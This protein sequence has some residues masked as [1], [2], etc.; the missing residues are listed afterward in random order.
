MITSI[1]S[2]VTAI[3]SFIFNFPVKRNDPLFGFQQAFTTLSS[4]TPLGVNLI[5]KTSAEIFVDRTHHET[6]VKSPVA[7]HLSPSF[8]LTAKDVKRRASSYNR[9]Y[10]EVLRRASLLD[11]PPSLQ[12]QVLDHAAASLPNLPLSRRRLRFVY[13]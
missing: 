1:K 9:A 8:V 10:F 13:R 12:I 6:V 5:S 7:T 4:V 3:S 2:K 11:L